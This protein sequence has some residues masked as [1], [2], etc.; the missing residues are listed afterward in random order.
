M[1]QH[2]YRLKHMKEHDAF[3][4]YSGLVWLKWR[5]FERE[6]EARPEGE[7]PRRS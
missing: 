5:I 6:T 3:G 4:E 2:I 1:K 7:Q